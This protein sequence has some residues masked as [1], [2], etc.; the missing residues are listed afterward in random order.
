MKN[1][2]EAIQSE[3]HHGYKRSMLDLEH[4]KEQRLKAA[5]FWK[6]YQLQNIDVI[7]E[8]ETKQ[9]QDEFENEKALLKEKMIHQNSDKTKKIMEEKNLLNLVDSEKHKTRKRGAREDKSHKNQHNVPLHNP[10]SIEYTLN[11]HDILEDLAMIKKAVQC[12]PTYTRLERSGMVSNF[13]TREIPTKRINQE[14]FVSKGRLHYFDTVLDKGMEI[15]IS[16][17]LC[18]TAKWTGVI[19]DITPAEIQITTPETTKARFSL[20]HL[21][22]KKIQIRGF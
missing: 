10:P 7:Y 9:I 1:E 8:A 4:Q 20:S 12:H 15:S 5:D 6:K 18:H 2:Q 3:D 11:D 16:S 19:C 14:V 22:T 21:R 17:S 13:N